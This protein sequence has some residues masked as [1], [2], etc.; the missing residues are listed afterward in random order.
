[1]AVSSNFQ[2]QIVLYFFYFKGGFGP[3]QGQTIP[4]T[5]KTAAGSGQLTGINPFAAFNNNP[6]FNND[7][8]QSIFRGFGISSNS[9]SNNGLIG[10]TGVLPGNQ[11]VVFK[12]IIFDCFNKINI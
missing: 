3:I 12:R 6:L 9:T 2:I 11:K 4:P 8:F 1:M 10:S 5:K 7:A